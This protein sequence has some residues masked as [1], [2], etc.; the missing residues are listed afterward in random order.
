[1]TERDHEGADQGNSGE[2]RGLSRRGL[3]GS[4]AGVGAATLAM[5]ALPGN[6]QKAIAATTTCGS[7]QRAHLSQQS[8]ARSGG[9]SPGRRDGLPRS[10]RV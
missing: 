6:V 8:S 4:A 7:S 10:R 3:L 2:R 5:T 9:R 1:M